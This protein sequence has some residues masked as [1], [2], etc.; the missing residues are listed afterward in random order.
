MFLYI[1]PKSETQI[2]RVHAKSTRLRAYFSSE[3]PQGVV[4]GAAA[5]SSG[6]GPSLFAMVEATFYTHAVLSMENQTCKYFYLVGA[7]SITDF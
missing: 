4:P 3:L 2:L 7:S 1:R 6:G 5:L